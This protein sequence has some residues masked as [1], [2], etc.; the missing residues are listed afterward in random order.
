MAN[1]TPIMRS[2]P[3]RAWKT[4]KT[5]CTHSALWNEGS[6]TPLLCRNKIWPFD[7]RFWPLFDLY[8]VIAKNLTDFPRRHQ[9]FW[10]Q[11]HQ[12][13]WKQL[14][15]LV[16][17][18]RSTKIQPA[19]R[20]NCRPS[21][22]EGCLSSTSTLFTCNIKQKQA[23]QSENINSLLHGMQI[24]WHKEITIIRIKYTTI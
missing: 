17:P 6:H 10:N 14:R 18:Q 20:V 16:V 21:E 13:R 7:L 9:N 5:C 23:Q 4:S 11:H 15:N 22:S 8:D 19:P 24:K 2:W 1:L 12:I 3:F